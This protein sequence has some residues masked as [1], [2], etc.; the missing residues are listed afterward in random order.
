LIRFFLIF[1]REFEE[2]SNTP[3]FLGYAM[4]AQFLNCSNKD[5][6][7]ARAMKAQKGSGDIATFIFNLG[8]RLVNSRSGR[9]TTDKITT[10]PMQQ[11]VGQTPESV[12]TF[13]I[14]KKETL[15]FV[16]NE[17]QSENLHVAFN[18]IQI[19]VV[20]CQLHRQVVL[21]NTNF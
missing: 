16:S 21:L 5:K 17:I 2:Q 9:F 18:I 12:W 6:D 13:G 1:W 20:E 8:R 11:E 4:F 19:V 10:V 3:E 15:V 7:P 14:I